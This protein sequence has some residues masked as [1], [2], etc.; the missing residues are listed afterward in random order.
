MK[1]ELKTTEKDPRTVR[2]SL[3]NHLKE[4][5]DR[6]IYHMVITY[7]KY[8]DISYS[9]DVVNTFFINF[10]LKDFLPYVMNS[11]HYNHDAQRNTQPLCFAFLDDHMTDALKKYEEEF[12]MKSSRENNLW[13]RLHHHA[14]VAIH[15]SHINRINSLIDPIELEGINTIPKESSP[16]I[17]TTYIAKRTPDV[18]NYASK[19][20]YKYPDFLAFPDRWSHK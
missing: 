2:E 13:N 8:A 9:E 16:K 6:T 12:T 10:Y 18:L 5:E 17:L 15:N 20:L 3:I 1:R 11:K 7:K 14:V 4:Q 19:R